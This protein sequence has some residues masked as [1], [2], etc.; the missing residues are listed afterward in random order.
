MRAFRQEQK[1]PPQREPANVT[2]WRNLAPAVSLQAKLTVNAPGDIYEQEAERVSE[3]VMRGP[4]SRLQPTCPCA[5]GCPRCQSKQPGRGREQLQ[6]DRVHPSEEGE[7]A[8]PPI[9]T[10][11]LLSSGRPLDSATRAFMEPRFGHDF[12]RVRVHTDARAAESARAVNALAY[13]V[14]RDLVFSQ[15]K[16]EPGSEQ[17]RRLL[18][19][20]LTH[21]AQ[22]SE[23]PQRTGMVQRQQPSGAGPAPSPAP[24]SAPVYNP[25]VNHNHPPSGRWASVQANPNSS[26]WANLACAHFPPNTVVGIAI[27]QEFSNK[28]IALDHLNWYLGNGQGADYVED[29]NLATLLRADL[30]VRALLAGLIPSSAPASGRF[31]GHVEV[32]QGHYQNQDFRYAFGAIDRLDFEVDFTAGTAHAWFQDRYEWHPV[33]PG[34]YAALPGDVVRE[35]NCVHAALVELKSGGARDF[36]MKGEATVPL[37]LFRGV[38]SS[39]GGGSGGSSL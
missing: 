9:I 27:R 33:Y 19:H 20:E 4:E 3:E 24:A 21:V 29:T 17:G 13:T 11:V 10:E 8:V 7:M 35:T 34:L 28:P 26:R 6:I 38:P 1:R 14:G 5:G 39:S 30:G 32:Q 31:T 22:Q 2:R 36:W 15:G 18:A 16:Y 12:S 37:S 25:G 23:T